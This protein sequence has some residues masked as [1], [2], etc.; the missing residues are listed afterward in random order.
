[1]YDALAALPLPQFASRSLNLT[2][3]IHRATNVIL[4]RQDPKASR[5]VYALQATDSEPLEIALSSPRLGISL[6]ARSPYQFATIASGLNNVNISEH[7]PQRTY[8]MTKQQV[9]H[10]VSFAETTGTSQPEVPVHAGPLSAHGH[11]A[12]YLEMPGEAIA[13]ARG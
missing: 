12:L 11:G 2:C 10:S 7:R 6:E 1:M 9:C 13:E 3:V 4:K 5:Y 8:S